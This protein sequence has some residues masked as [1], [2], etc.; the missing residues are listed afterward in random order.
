MRDDPI[1]DNPRRE[2]SKNLRDDVYEDLQ[3]VHKEYDETSCMATDLS[4]FEYLR[5]DNDG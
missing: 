2:F 3:D 4:R 5:L 1:I